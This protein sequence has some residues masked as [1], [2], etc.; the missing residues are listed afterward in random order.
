MTSGVVKSSEL[1]DLFTNSASLAR[2][3]CQSVRLLCYSWPLEQDDSERIE[4][5]V[6]AA[7][8]PR[9]DLTWL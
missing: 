8:R 3:M 1:I 2:V 4:A 7:A 6:E 5:E 9:I